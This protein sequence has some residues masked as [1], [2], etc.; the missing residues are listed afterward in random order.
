[1]GGVAEMEIVAK[2]DKEDLTG[3]KTTLAGADLSF[4]VTWLKALS[5][6]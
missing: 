2:Q 4:E 5:V 6:G 3:L 1:M